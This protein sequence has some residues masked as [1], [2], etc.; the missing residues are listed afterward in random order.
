MAGLWSTCF[1][2]GLVC[3]WVSASEYKGMFGQTFSTKIDLPNT[4]GA[5][6]FF[7]CGLIIFA[8]NRFAKHTFFLQISGGL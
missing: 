2:V 6:F 5:I 7:W 4:P 1:T 3:V 8:E